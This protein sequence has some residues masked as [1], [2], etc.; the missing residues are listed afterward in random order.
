MNADA[1]KERPAAA[2]ITVLIQKSGNLEPSVRFSWLWCELTLFIPV[3]PEPKKTIQNII[4]SFFTAD[5]GV[6]DKF[7][8]SPGFF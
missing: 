3:S 8:S 7:F 5:I 2:L 4:S 6:S 1:Q